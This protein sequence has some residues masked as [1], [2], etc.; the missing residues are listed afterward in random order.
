[1]VQTNQTE[2]LGNKSFLTVGV[3]RSESLVPVGGGGK[4]RL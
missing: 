2:L 4:A 3:E 1:M